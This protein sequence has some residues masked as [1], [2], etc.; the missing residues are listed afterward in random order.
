MTTEQHV[1]S[2][3][4]A[5]APEQIF[6]VLTDPAQHPHTEPGDWVR[7]SLEPDPAPLTEVGQLFG[8]EMFHEAAGGR[9]DIHNKVSTL[10]QERAIAWIPGQL[11]DGHWGA[12]GWWW[13]YDLAPVDGGTD[14]TMTYDWTDVPQQ[15]RDEFGGMPAVPPE[16]LEESLAALDRYVTLGE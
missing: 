3:T 11:E 10:E 12:G 6:A 2:R 4:I 16:F 14:V 15:V 8:I 13:R 5:A 1:R 9:Y 7:A